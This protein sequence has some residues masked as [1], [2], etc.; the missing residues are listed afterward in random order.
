MLVNV[1]ET[2]KALTS[3]LVFRPYIKLADG[4]VIYGAKIETSIRDVAIS[5]YFSSATD[6]ETKSY[7]KEILDICEFDENEV[8][9]PLDDLWN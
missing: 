3:E 2:K 4:S 8:F 9:L 5:L 7:V 1:P 6:E